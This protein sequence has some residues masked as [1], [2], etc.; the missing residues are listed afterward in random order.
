MRVTPGMRRRSTSICLKKI[1]RTPRCVPVTLPPGLARLRANPSPTGSKR[2]TTIGRFGAAFCSQ[3]TRKLRSRM[4]PSYLPLA[5]S[6]TALGSFVSQSLRMGTTCGTSSRSTP[7]R[8]PS[9][10]NGLTNIAWMYARKSLG[11]TPSSTSSMASSATRFIPGLAASLPGKPAANAPAAADA[12]KRRR[13]N[14]SPVRRRLPVDHDP[15]GLDGDVSALN[16]VLEDAAHHLARAADAARDL[17]LG[18]LLGDVLHA[19][20]RD[21]ALQQQA[22]HAPVGVHEREA[23]H[24][25]GEHPD[26]PD[27]LV[28]E[29]VGEG[30]M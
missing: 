6:C 19:V 5:I 15:V 3:C 10:A 27:Q 14:R 8:R 16:Q 17:G 23:A 25:L 22:C 13:L 30:G 21:R 2:W 12:R 7:S 4:A 18:E 1:S 26:A 9:S 29:V 11:T 24:V 20:L 28:D